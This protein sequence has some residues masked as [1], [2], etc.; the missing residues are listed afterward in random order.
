MHGWMD[1]WMEWMDGW[2]DGWMDGL[3][4]QLISQSSLITH[5]RFDQKQNIIYNESMNENGFITYTS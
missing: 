3:I 4:I 1:G 2:I 5:L